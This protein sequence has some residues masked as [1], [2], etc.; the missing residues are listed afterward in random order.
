MWREEGG[1]RGVGESVC[2]GREGGREGG[3][4]TVRGEMCCVARGEGV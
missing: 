4:S 1:E 2:G 3:G